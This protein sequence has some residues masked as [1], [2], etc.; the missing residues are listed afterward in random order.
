MISENE[1]DLEEGV[2]YTCKN[3]VWPHI[4]GRGMPSLLA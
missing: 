4:M 2:P 3:L 1:C